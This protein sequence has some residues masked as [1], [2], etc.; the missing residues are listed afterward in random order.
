MHELGDPN[1]VKKLY[2]KAILITHPDRVN[3]SATEIRFLASRIFGAL[4][5][6]WKV[7]EQ[8]GQ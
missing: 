3:K 2:R 6:A 4:N 8:T 5:E 7:F 1:S